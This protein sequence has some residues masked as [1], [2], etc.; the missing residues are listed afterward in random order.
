MLEDDWKGLNKLPTF[1]TKNLRR[2]L[3]IFW[4]KVIS[5]QHLL[6]RCNQDSMGTII[7]QGQWGWIGHMMR[8]EPANISCT[9]LHST[10]E[11]KWKWGQ[12]KNTWCQT[13]E[14][15]LKPLHHTWGTVQKLAKNRQEWLLLSYMPAGI[16]GMSEWSWPDAPNC[17]SCLSLQLSPKVVSRLASYFLLSNMGV[18]LP[19]Q[20]SSMIY[21]SCLATLLGYYSGWFFRKY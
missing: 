15:E 2:I 4:P 5:N 9:G 3:W 10:P 1:H 17:V 16:T 20:K 19:L 21:S 12:S 6:T 11:G 7:M 14:V 13:V 18:P 8:R